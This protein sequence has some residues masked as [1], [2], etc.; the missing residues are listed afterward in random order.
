MG[1]G[2][3]V[4]LAFMSKGPVALLETIVPFA[5]Y[6]A[7]W[8]ARSTWARQQSLSAILPM[9]VSVMVCLVVS[10]PWFVAVLAS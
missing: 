7:L 3:A 1:A 10:L 9:I 5:A 8:Q 4:G 2:I 6:V